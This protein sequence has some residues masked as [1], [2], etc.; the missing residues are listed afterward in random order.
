M[1]RF[2]Q[3]FDTIR[4]ALEEGA[5]MP[6]RAHDTDAGLDLYAMEDAVVRAKSVQVFDTGVHLELPQINLYDGW[7]SYRVNTG[8]FI[9]SKSGLFFN[10]DILTVG[11]EDVGYTGTVG[12]KLCNFGVVDYHVKRGDKIAQIVIVPVL[13]PETLEVVS[14]EEF[15]QTERGTGGFG[16][17]G[18]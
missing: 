7:S 16:S 6:T 14:V 4:I 13:T 10:H 5:I 3:G 12:V 1:R 8:G 9:E 15:G 17:T 2:N 11:L 18:K